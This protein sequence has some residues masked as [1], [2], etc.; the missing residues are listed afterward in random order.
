MQL[1]HPDETR[2]C[3]L[4]SPVSLLRQQPCH[5]PDVLL[6][7]KRNGNYPASAASDAT[8]TPVRRDRVSA[9]RAAWLDPASAIAHN[10]AEA[11]SSAVTI[12]FDMDNTLVDEFGATVRPGMAAL[13]R[14]LRKDGHTLVLWTNSAR[15]RAAEIL[16]LHGLRPHFAKCLFREDYDPEDRGLPKDIRKVKAG[17]LIDDDPALCAFVRARGGRALQVSPYRKGRP[18]DLEQ[19]RE[20]YRAISQAA[21]RGRWWP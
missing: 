21:R 12:V 1:R 13:L 18:A 4:Y 17:L 6:Q 2:V 8:R 3:E 14:R 10:G 20:L 16:R 5:W 15:A 9:G 11:G 7:A 19:I